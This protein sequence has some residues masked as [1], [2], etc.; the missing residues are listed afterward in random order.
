MRVTIALFDYSSFSSSW[1]EKCEPAW[2]DPYA[3]T[4]IDE[5]RNVLHTAARSFETVS[6]WENRA[7]K[8]RSVETVPVSA[9][10]EA[11]NSNSGKLHFYLIKQEFLSKF[12]SFLYLRSTKSDRS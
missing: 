5:L 12:R 2:E 4:S 9:I 11:G 7:S 8:R 3:R 6:R 1:K 10:N